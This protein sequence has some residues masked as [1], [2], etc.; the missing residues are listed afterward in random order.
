MWC[1]PFLDSFMKWLIG[2]LANAIPIHFLDGVYIL[3][4]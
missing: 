3:A 4:L 2:L 1:Q